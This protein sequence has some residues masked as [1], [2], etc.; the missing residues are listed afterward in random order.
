[1]VPILARRTR[2]A[3][4]LRGS[5]RN[6]GMATS[7]SIFHPGLGARKKC[8]T[9]A[10]TLR[11]LFVSTHRA[12]S[13]RCFLKDCRKVPFQV[14]FSS[15]EIGNFT[16]RPRSRWGA[17]GSKYIKGRLRPSP[18]KRVVRTPRIGGRAIGW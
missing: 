2:K 10:L 12:P 8:S 18:H 14:F 17:G 15:D 5:L 13:Q 7:R 4:P 3:I 6:T 1:M 9:H 16:Y 11:F